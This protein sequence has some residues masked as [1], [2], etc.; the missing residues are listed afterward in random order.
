MPAGAP[1][2]GDRHDARA[3]YDLEHPTQSDFLAPGREVDADHRHR[4]VAVR[5][6]R[7]AHRFSGIPT[8]LGTRATA[9]ADEIERHPLRSTRRRG[10][11]TSLHVT[12]NACPQRHLAVESPYLAG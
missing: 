2:D 12:Y 4:G 6:H 3:L 9:R 7:G 11:P 10:L 8:A 5:A 1:L